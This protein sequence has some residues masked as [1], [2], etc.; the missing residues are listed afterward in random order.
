MAHS[1]NNVPLRSALKQ[2]SR[3]ASPTNGL[4]SPTMSPQISRIPLPLS[5]ST[6]TATLSISRVHSRSSIHDS[7]SPGPLLQSPQGLISPSYTPKV[8]FDT[9]ENPVASMFSFTLQVKTEGYR[10]TRSTRVFLCAS[11]PD[12][13]GSE[14]LEWSIES[15]V[16][17][18]DELVVFRGADED[19][20][21]KD[22]NLVREEARDLMRSIQEKSVEYD[23][24]RKL[25]LVL[26]YIPGKV[27]DSLDRLI[28]LYRPDS[29]V[30]GTRGRRFGASLVQGLGVGLVQGL[31]GSGSA[32]GSVSKYCLA[33]SPVPVIVVRPGR[34]LRKA[35]EKRRANPKRGQHF[36]ST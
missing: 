25:S 32:I 7:P 3:P 36:E 8:S 34:K 24:E 31:G 16:Q 27:T 33:H 9:F 23:P 17:D 15:L 11:S 1:H 5:P 30:V 2:S 14:A 19:V 10:R 35:A 26:E 6:S 28:A 21:Q 20:L 12:E 29:L 22:H 18:G 4:A 13:S